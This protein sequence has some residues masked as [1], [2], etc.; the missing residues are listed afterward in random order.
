LRNKIA[1]FRNNVKGRPQGYV[2]LDVAEVSSLDTATRVAAGESL[3][4]WLRHRWPK[5]V[6]VVTLIEPLA[7]DLQKAQ[8]SE[9]FLRGKYGR[10]YLALSNPDENNE[11]RVEVEG[12]LRVEQDPSY[13]TF[14]SCWEIHPKNRDVIAELQRRDAY[15]FKFQ[16]AVEKFVRRLLHKEPRFRGTGKELLCRVMNELDGVITIITFGAREELEAEGLDTNSHSRAH[17]QGYIDRRHQERVEALEVA[18]EAGDAG[19]R[20][21]L[22]GLAEAQIPIS[23]RILSNPDNVR[24]I[25]DDLRQQ[26]VDTLTGLLSQAL[27]NNSLEMGYTDFGAFIAMLIE[28]FPLQERS[29]SDKNPYGL[30]RS[31]L[32][33]YSFIGRLPDAITNE[34]KIIL[35]E[36]VL[37]SVLSTCG[38]AGRDAAESLA[39]TV[40]DFIERVSVSSAEQISR[41]IGEESRRY[42]N[43]NAIERRRRALEAMGDVQL[44]G[45]RAVELARTQGWYQED[46]SFVR[47]QMVF[48]EQIGLAMLEFFNMA[49]QGALEAIPPAQRQDSTDSGTAIADRGIFPHRGEG[50]VNDLI[51]DILADN[52]DYFVR[53]RGIS[54]E[55]ARTFRTS[56][57][58]LK[59]DDTNVPL[60][61]RPTWAKLPIEKL[62]DKDIIAGLTN[63][64]RLHVVRLPVSELGRIN[65][66]QFYAHHGLREGVIW[67]AS[68]RDEIDVLASIFHEI[69]EYQLASQE[70]KKRGWTMEDMARWRDAASPEALEFFYTNHRKAWQGVIDLCTTMRD[71]YTN[72]LVVGS[73]EVEYADSLSV[74]RN[75]FAAV[76]ERV[77]TYLAVG[78]EGGTSVSLFR[79]RPARGRNVMTPESLARTGVAITDDGEARQPLPSGLPTE[80]HFHI[81]NFR[82]IAEWYL[83]QQDNRQEILRN[84]TLDTIATLLGE[85][86]T[87]VYALEPMAKMD[88]YLPI[89][90]VF[91]NDTSSLLQDIRHADTNRRLG[92][93]IGSAIE[94]TYGRFLLNLPTVFPQEVLLREDVQEQLRRVEE[95]FFL[96][97]FLVSLCDSLTMSEN[98]A[99]IEG[100]GRLMKSAIDAYHD[101]ILPYHGREILIARQGDHFSVSLPFPQDVLDF[102]VLEMVK[103][104]VKASPR[105]PDT[106]LRAGVIYLRAYREANECVIQVEDRGSGIAQED[107]GDVK[108]VGVTAGERWRANTGTGLS[109][110]ERIAGF[111]GG[112]LEITSEPGGPTIQTI[113]LPLPSTQDAMPGTAIADRGIFP[114]RGEGFVNDNIATILYENLDRFVNEERITEKDREKFRRWYEEE[115]N[116]GDDVPKYFKLPLTRK[117]GA[118]GLTNKDDT[119]RAT[120]GKKL[121]VVRLPVSELGH[122]DGRAFYAHI[123]LKEGIVWVAGDR[124]YIDVELS[125][126]HE[127]EEYDAASQEAERRGWTMAQMAEWRDNPPAHE[128]EVARQFFQEAHRRSWENIS[129]FCQGE[130]SRLDD[131]IAKAESERHKFIYGR[132]ESLIDTLRRLSK[133]YKLMA[134]RADTYIEEF[135]K[136]EDAAQEA[137][138]HGNIGQTHAQDAETVELAKAGARIAET[139]YYMRLSRNN[140]MVV[141]RNINSVGAPNTEAIRN[142]LAATM[143]R[144]FTH[145]LLIRT[146]ATY[147]PR[148]KEDLAARLLR[149]T[150]I[151]FEREIGEEN[152][153]RWLS[154]GER[155]TLYGIM[156]SYGVADT[157]TTRN[158]MAAIIFDMTGERSGEIVDALTPNIANQSPERALEII[159]RVH[160]VIPQRPQPR[161]VELEFGW[162]SDLTPEEVFK[163]GLERLMKKLWSGW[164]YEAWDYVEAEVLVAY[165]DQRPIGVWAFTRT[166]EEGRLQDNGLH[167]DETLRAQ[168]VKGIGTA[169]QEEL[170]RRFKKQGVGVFNIGFKGMRL[171]KDPRFFNRLEGRK[172][173]IVERFPDGAIERVVINVQEFEP[174]SQSTI[175]IPGDVLQL[176]TRKPLSKM[177]I[178]LYGPPG[179]GKGTQA[180]MLEGRGLTHISSSDL[181]DAQVRLGTPLGREVKGYM[182]TGELVPD[183]I[184]IG[185]VINRIRELGLSSGFV[186]DGYPR[187]EEQAR[188]LETALSTDL[189]ISIDRVVSLE[190]SPEVAKFRLGG[191]LVC[192]V[193]YEGCGAVYNIKDFP[194]GVVRV[195]TTCRNELTQRQDDKDPKAVDRRLAIYEEEMQGVRL[196][197]DNKGILRSV[198]VSDKETEKEEVFTEL[199]VAL[200]EGGT[201]QVVRR[202]NQHGA[203]QPSIGLQEVGLDIVH[204]HESTTLDL[205][206]PYVVTGAL[207]RRLISHV[208]EH[209][210]HEEF[211]SAIPSSYG[212]RLIMNSKHGY[213]VEDLEGSSFVF[214]GGA[215]G[216]CHRDAFNSRIEDCLKADRDRIEFHFPRDAIY[217]VIPD[218]DATIGATNRVIPLSRERFRDGLDKYTSGHTGCRVRFINGRTGEVIAQ[219]ESGEQMLVDVFL[220][221]TLHE[222]LVALQG[223]QPLLPEETTPAT[224]LAQRDDRKPQLGHTEGLASYVRDLNDAL[225]EQDY[226][227]AFEVIIAAVNEV[228]RENDAS[229][230]VVNFEPF[231]NNLRDFMTAVYPNHVGPGY[232]ALRPL[233]EVQD[234]LELKRESRMC[235][236]RIAKSFCIEEEIGGI[237]AHTGEDHDEIC[238][239]M[240]ANSDRFPE[241][242]NLLVLDSHLDMAKPGQVDPFSRGVGNWISK[243]RE[244]FGRVYWYVSPLAIRER[245]KEK[246]LSYE[247]AI[248]DI[249]ADYADYDV[250]IITNPDEL[251]QVEGPTIVSVDVDFFQAD[252]AKVTVGM[253][254]HI[255]EPQEVESALGAICN[256]DALDRMQVVGLDFSLTGLPYLPQERA[257]VLQFMA[258]ERF[259]AALG[260]S[261]STQ[262][263]QRDDRRGAIAKGSRSLEKFADMLGD[264]AEAG[265]TEHFSELSVEEWRRL[266]EDLTAVSSIGGGRRAP[267]LSDAIVERMFEAPLV[268]KMPLIKEGSDDYMVD[269]DSRHP[270]VSDEMREDMQMV[271]GTDNVLFISE[272]ILEIEDDSVRREAIAHAFSCASLGHARAIDEQVKAF[273]EN[274]QNAEGLE[275]VA[276]ARYLQK[277]DLGRYLSDKLSTRKIIDVRRIDLPEQHVGTSQELRAIV[278]EPLL[279][280]CQLLFDRGI[281]TRLSSANAMDVPAGYVWI[282]IDRD[283][284]SKENLQRADELCSGIDR[285]ELW[286]SINEDSTV[287]EVKKEA[288]KLAMMFKNQKDDVAIPL[289]RDLAARQITRDAMRTRDLLRHFLPAKVI[290][291]NRYTIELN[292][293]RM[294]HTQLEIAKEWVAR[295]KAKYP[296][297]SFRV[298][299]VARSESQVS[300]STY[301]ETSKGIKIGESHISTQ[302]K[303]A[304]GEVFHRTIGMMNLCFIAANVPEDLTPE[305]MK[306]NRGLIDSIIAQYAAL[307]DGALLIK[308]EEYTPQ[309]INATIR[310][311]TIILEPAQ[312]IDFNEFDELEIS[313]RALDSAA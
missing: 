226:P 100:P 125:I 97:E 256:R 10:V 4:R 302:R 294:T 204:M 223:V 2:L 136:T 264:T 104:A 239:W 185:L 74:A 78:A 285:D 214:T 108:K 190:V 131:S 199:L 83:S 39:Q 82:Q 196:F 268:I 3:S 94:T 236:A 227:R 193:R 101:Y 15:V 297:C 209:Y 276:R 121:R 1:V 144:P 233:L 133:D 301:A 161:E 167:V 145:Q 183:R 157:E 201:A 99:S 153:Y 164:Y 56:I 102:F 134:W 55:E 123:G 36:S 187:T 35:A 188:S 306:I 218:E 313:R 179:G 9:G 64:R 59:R 147:L 243:R 180:E 192:D 49:L 105:L 273:E 116:P 14:V 298:S 254:T 275:G 253:I 238:D 130:A 96:T 290:D 244:L 189:G 287:E 220:W 7:K 248:A 305:T 143:F 12:F 112:S 154:D 70:A 61:A 221:D 151:Q 207:D 5:P 140:R 162:M 215:W 174:S 266:N 240:D 31:V 115:R 259:A 114:H 270:R 203:I 173:A 307:M 186:L 231:M 202:D 43:Q 308:R 65:G 19:A 182:D 158:I 245:A 41:A 269:I 309:V 280:A 296:N 103:N 69:V 120:N 197:Y 146:L 279:E 45:A 129:S 135:E 175:I 58:E 21:I 299:T 111:Y 216:V 54:E 177:R 18:A 205:N 184:M 57:N 95:L 34:H 252:T 149:Q 85:A 288:I 170:I 247:E 11:G 208:Y 286:I 71:G 88:S 224:Q 6:H 304:T 44:M 117:W 271:F 211:R 219:E 241:R 42:L 79:R 176:A 246:G 76:I 255:L 77:E 80:P 217:A 22:G 213:H 274:R 68:K 200:G 261:R 292:A 300:I 165:L 113:R 137:L 194:Q 106:R 60:V 206:I 258:R 40:E 291:G 312:R 73:I 93:L 281:T 229:L 278:E 72:K 28:Q 51:V 109:Q 37:P 198:S 33:L 24:R 141:T 160:E 75:K 50:F 148:E 91:F 163:S 228:M 289:S 118:K 25:V 17:F 138:A 32:A 86:R 166:T 251:Q 168:G 242:P 90:R 250:T 30:L 27:E 122:I 47:H 232:D 127:R 222:A 171:I 212:S 46:R 178:I 23:E 159:R 272:E 265:E 119:I 293:A 126:W 38:V 132:E 67:V 310:N 26:R 303:E 260:V 107:I 181:L 98:T 237:P 13:G 128:I 139:P 249:R 110:I 156:R 142:L 152:S 262:L 225:S 62:E 283:T 84:Y 234:I 210:M 53:E 81:S 66:K 52:L 267:A 195:C 124:N 29:Q 48:G 282:K 89:Y 235:L 92:V 16:I 20:H 172:G 311:M 191:R 295:L 257:V 169:L 263:A 277:G 150:Y 284:L 155:E 8:V 230:S 63:G 87:I